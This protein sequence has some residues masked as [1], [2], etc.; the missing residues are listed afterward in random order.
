MIDLDDLAGL[1]PGLPSESA[2]TLTLRARVALERRHQPGVVMNVTVRGEDKHETIRWSRLPLDVAPTQDELRATEEGAVAIALA[3]SARHCKWRVVRCLQ[4]RLAEGADWL[5][6]D[7]SNRRVVLEVGG[8]D[9]GNVDA[10]LVR[11]MEQARRS[12]FSRRGRAAA[13][14]VRFVE[15]RALL[16]SQD[17][18][19]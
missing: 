19:R 18:H 4:S 5:M 9:G 13:C 15:P 10:L 2:G 17:G 7:G 12:I 11:K 16:W 1:C 8:T 14:V 3:L 6:D